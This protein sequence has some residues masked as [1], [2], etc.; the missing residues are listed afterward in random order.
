MV[1]NIS[2]RPLE[3]ERS[4][5]VGAGGEKAI[6][7]PIIQSRRLSLSPFQIGSR[8]TQASK[9]I[10]KFNMLLLHLKMRGALRF[11]V[12][13]NTQQVMI[14]VLAISTENRHPSSFKVTLFGP[15][16]ARLAQ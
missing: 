6:I 12:T 15:R 13:F 10:Y 1:D 9:I 4:E 3:G 8:T 2:P 5:G 14:I 16:R 7:I 11:I